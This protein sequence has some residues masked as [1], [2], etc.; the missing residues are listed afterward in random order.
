MNLFDSRSAIY[1][2][3]SNKPILS[4]SNDNPPQT[5]FVQEGNPFTPCKFNR[6]PK[7]RTCTLIL[8]KT[9]RTSM[10]IGIKTPEN[11]TQY[12][13]IMQLMPLCY[14]CLERVTTVAFIYYFLPLANVIFLNLQLPQLHQNQ[15]GS[16]PHHQQGQGAWYFLTSTW[17]E[18]SAI[19]ENSNC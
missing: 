7:G 18:N 2:K 6:K 3:H 14:N 16:L 17:N 12:R 13:L 15:S 11:Q 1:E 9:Y 4:L 8:A 10:S 5:L 19:R